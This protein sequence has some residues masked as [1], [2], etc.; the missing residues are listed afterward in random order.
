MWY[1]SKECSFSD[2]DTFQQVGVISWFSNLVVEA[3]KDLKL[4]MLNTNLDNLI[5]Y[6]EEI[7]D[8]G[9]LIYIEKPY[10]SSSSA[11]KQ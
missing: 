11:A 5:M 1:Y 2:T 8:D 3:N 4:K 7:T 9:R 6:I 10:S